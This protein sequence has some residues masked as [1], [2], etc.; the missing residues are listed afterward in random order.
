MFVKV[1]FV[2]YHLV[3]QSPLVVAIVKKKRECLTYLNTKHSF[4]NVHVQ[5]TQ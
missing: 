2:L 4:L 3:F 1:I 5:L